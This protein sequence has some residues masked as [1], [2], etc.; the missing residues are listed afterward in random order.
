MSADFDGD[1]DN[2]KS[3]S[4]LKGS[5]VTHWQTHGTTEYP[6][7]NTLHGD[8]SVN[9]QSIRIHWAANRSKLYVYDFYIHMVCGWPS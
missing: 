6:L 3:L 9:C 1:A 4:Y 8:K 2:F 5:S 7:C